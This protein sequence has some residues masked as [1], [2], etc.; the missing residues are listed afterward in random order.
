M[1]CALSLKLIFFFKFFT[2]LNV[3][4]IIGRYSFYVALYEAYVSKRFFRFSKVARDGHK[5]LV[6]FFLP[7]RLLADM[8][9]KTKGEMRSVHYANQHYHYGSIHL[10]FFLKIHLLI[11]Y[12]LEIKSVY[13]LLNVYFYCFISCILLSR[14]RDF[15]QKKSKLTF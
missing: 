7:S 5:S 1:Q 10:V 9:K 2:I 8:L 14:D 4:T 15:F 13:Y 3:A 12:E 11:K 6:N